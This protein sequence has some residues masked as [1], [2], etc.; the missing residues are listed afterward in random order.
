MGDPK[1]NTMWAFVSRVGGI[2]GWGWLVASSALR[3]GG[4]KGA[5]GTGA[6]TKHWAP[7]FVLSPFRRQTS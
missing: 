6:W 7:P 3:V 2:L 1:P 5:V 4:A